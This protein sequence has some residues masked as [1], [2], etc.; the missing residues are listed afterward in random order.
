MKGQRA[1]DDAF[2]QGVMAPVRMPEVTGG[3]IVEVDIIATFF[4]FHATG[5]GS[6]FGT[7]PHVGAY[8]SIRAT[9]DFCREFGTTTAVFSWHCSAD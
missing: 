3:T 6:P 2:S 4:L 8:I 5:A 9:A 7:W 1:T